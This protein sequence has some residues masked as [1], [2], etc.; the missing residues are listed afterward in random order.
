MI[1]KRDRRIKDNGG[2]D[3]INSASVYN[4][5][6]LAIKSMNHYIRMS[7]SEGTSAIN[8]YVSIKPYKIHYI[9][10]VSESNINRSL[11]CVYEIT[12][13]TIN[14][15]DSITFAV[16]NNITFNQ[17]SFI[18]NNLP[19]VR[20]NIDIHERGYSSGWRIEET[21]GAV[22][23]YNYTPNFETKEWN[24]L[25]P[26]HIPMS[27]IYNMIPNNT[28]GYNYDGIAR[29]FYDIIST[30]PSNIRP[31]NINVNLNGLNYIQTFSKSYASGKTITIYYDK[32]LTGLPQPV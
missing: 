29:D 3:V 4:A 18:G 9:D 31:F 16:M 19:A 2:D 5:M 12:F 13:P 26:E 21:P 25:F 17:Q 8:K 7:D 30:I 24:I 32:Y 15:G 20:G 27:V 28:Y 1:I 14:D 23:Y 11:Y 6:N 22:K 10:N